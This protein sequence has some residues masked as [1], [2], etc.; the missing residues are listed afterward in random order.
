MI[1]TGV[2]PLNN[3]SFQVWSKALEDWYAD[4]YDDHPGKGISEVSSIITFVSQDPP[5][6]QRR[7]LGEA[8]NLQNQELKMVYDQTI[9]FQ[10]SSDSNLDAGGVITEP[11]ASESD[12]KQFAERLKATGNNAFADITSVSGV[13][14][15]GQGQAQADDGLSTA[16]IVGIA[17]GGAAG[18]V[19]LG[20]AGYWATHSGDGGYEKNIGDHPPSSLQLGGGDDVST[21]NDPTKSLRAADSA[22]GYGDQR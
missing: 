3:A 14:Q 17:V 4:F 11:L 19:L 13:S 18:L 22:G 2:D 10:N 15:E 21:L 6:T 7:G 1:M 12:Q 5:G 8:R 16:A 20:G 9:S